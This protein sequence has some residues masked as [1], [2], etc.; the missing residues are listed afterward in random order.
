MKISNLFLKKRKTAD[1]ISSAI[2]R[3]KFSGIAKTIIIPKI[4]IEKQSKSKKLISEEILFQQS[5]FYLISYG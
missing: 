2:F 5:I 4:E 3:L 1:L